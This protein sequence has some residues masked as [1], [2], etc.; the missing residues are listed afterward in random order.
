MFKDLKNP[1][2]LNT[3]MESAEIRNAYPEE[4]NEDSTMAF[5]ESSNETVPSVVDEI[6]E[7]LDP[8]SAFQ[9]S[10]PSDSGSFFHIFMNSLLGKLFFASLFNLHSAIS[11]NLD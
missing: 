2:F 11:E 7:Q 8:V 6:E 10:I 9:F 1:Y 5:K 3:H 4:E